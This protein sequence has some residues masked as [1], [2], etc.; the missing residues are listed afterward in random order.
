M[1]LIVRR[2]QTLA[3]WI[4]MVLLLCAFAPE[5]LAGALQATTSQVCGAAVVLGLALIKEVNGDG[6]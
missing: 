3:L 1:R 6:K 5:A 2:P 4:G